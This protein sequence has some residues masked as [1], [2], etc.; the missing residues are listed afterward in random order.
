MVYCLNIEYFDNASHSNG[1]LR[2]LNGADCSNGLTNKGLKI[3]KAAY[4]SDDL[5]NASANGVL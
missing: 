2:F 3:F 4:R 5:P 1:T